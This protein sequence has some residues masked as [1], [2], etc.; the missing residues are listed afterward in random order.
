MCL[1]VGAESLITE[2]TILRR[3]TLCNL[4]HWKMAV[5]NQGIDWAISGKNSRRPEL[6]YLV[7]LEALN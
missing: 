3:Q 4:H 1:Q 5:I 6:N 2:N 7:A